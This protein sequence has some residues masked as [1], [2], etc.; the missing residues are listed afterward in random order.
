MQLIESFIEGKPS[1]CTILTFQFLVNGVYIEKQ[2]I[3]FA[4]DVF[5]NNQNGP[6]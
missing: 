5:L 6:Y 3:D 2:K 1:E 4:N